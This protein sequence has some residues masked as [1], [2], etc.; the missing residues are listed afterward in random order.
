[1]SVDIYQLYK[2]DQPVL[3]GL[4]N[5]HTIEFFAHG[6]DYVAMFKGQLVQ[7]AELP[8][9]ILKAIERDISRH[10]AAA[11][12]LD[13]LGITERI[14]RITQYLWCR[15]GGFDTIPDM[16]GEKMGEPEYWP[17]PHRS[18]CP[19]EFKLC[20][21][22]SGPEG[23]LSKA[24]LKVVRLLGENPNMAD[25]Q[26]ADQLGLSKFTIMVHLSNIRYKMGFQSRG[27]IVA[28]AHQKGIVQPKFS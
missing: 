24:E 3:A 19:H 8:E 4:V 26:L 1:M 28:M 21:P 11:A 10:P 5:D 12:E 23:E 9:K 13:T 7:V 22:I 18:K 2:V 17:C 20:A 27:A 14:P 16:V 15:Y 6:Q 25:K